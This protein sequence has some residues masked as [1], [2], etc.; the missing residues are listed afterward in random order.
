MTR[1][2]RGDAL[3]LAKRRAE[4][5]A[6]LARYCDEQRRLKERLL[7]LPEWRVE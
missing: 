5:H 7:L 6:A 3:L 1:P 2:T 4:I